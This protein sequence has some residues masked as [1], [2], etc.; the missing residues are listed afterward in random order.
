MMAELCPPEE[1]FSFLLF[2]FKK[3]NPRWKEARWRGNGK[4]NKILVAG[5]SE[6]CF[7]DTELPPPPK[8]TVASHTFRH[9][10]ERTRCQR[11]PCLSSFFLMLLVNCN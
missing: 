9:I 10:G 2:F 4:D 11:R 3:K 1:P 7:N 5:R 6:R 8:D